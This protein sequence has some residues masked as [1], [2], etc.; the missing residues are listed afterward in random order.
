[1][2]LVGKFSDKT[3]VVIQLFYESLTAASHN[4]HFRRSSNCQAAGKPVNNAYMADAW[5][6]PF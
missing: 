6:G 2:A 1:M 5:T 3:L 4:S